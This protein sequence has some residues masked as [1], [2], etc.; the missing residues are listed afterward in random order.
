MCT[1]LP[2]G[3]VHVDMEMGLE[4]LAERFASQCGPRDRTVLVVHHGHIAPHIVERLAQLPKDIVVVQAGPDDVI[5]FLT[6]EDP[7]D[8]LVTGMRSV[9]EA[10]ARSMR[11]QEL[12]DEDHREAG[13]YRR[14]ERR[15]LR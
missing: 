2:S 6:V 10:A 13:W 8:V 9:T 12:R 3:A 4:Q 1:Q 11:K 14:F 15:R 7:V 5:P